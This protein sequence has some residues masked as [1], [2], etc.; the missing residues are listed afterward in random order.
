MSDDQINTLT[1]LLQKLVSQKNLET[2]SHNELPKRI[3]RSVR[4]IA[5]DMN[6]DCKTLSH[7]SFSGCGKFV[8]DAYIKHYNRRPLQ[9]CNNNC[10]YTKKEVK[11]IQPLIKKYFEMNT[12]DSD[13]NSDQNENS[14]D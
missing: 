9:R 14:H 13:N 4:D 6:L 12:S 11:F 3:L 8:K 10:L 1:Q 5:N 2:K 7:K